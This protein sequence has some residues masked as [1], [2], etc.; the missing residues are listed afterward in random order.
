MS[1]LF[2]DVS[3]IIGSPVSRRKMLG[4]VGGAVGGAVLA[5]LGLGEAYGDDHDNKPKC[6]KHQIVCGRTCCD[7]GQ[8]CCDGKCCGSKQVCCNG[9]CCSP[10]QTCCNGKCCSG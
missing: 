4:L 6:G 2:D 8:T 10:G 3:R 5:S 1:K 7:P 9:K